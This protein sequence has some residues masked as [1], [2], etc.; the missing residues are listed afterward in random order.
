LMRATVAMHGRRN[1]RFRSQLGL[2]KPGAPL[3]FSFQEH[4][5][6]KIFVE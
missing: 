4:P 5:G 1:V 3:G 6:H 2:V